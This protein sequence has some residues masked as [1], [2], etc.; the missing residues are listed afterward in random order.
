MNKRGAFNG[1]DWNKGDHYC[2][3]GE[4]KEVEE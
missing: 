2:S 4:K 3:Y 1:E